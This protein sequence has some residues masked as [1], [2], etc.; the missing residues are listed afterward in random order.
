MNSNV[1][2]SILLQHLE[3]YREYSYENLRQ[4]VGSVET[5]EISEPGGVRYQSEFQFFWDGQPNGNIRVIGSNDGGGWRA[6]APLSDD[7][8][9]SPNGEFAGE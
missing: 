9:K 6:F 4:L 1:A 7:F 5:E 3:R 8:I 2:R